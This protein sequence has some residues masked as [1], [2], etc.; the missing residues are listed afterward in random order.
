MMSF[1][2]SCTFSLRLIPFPRKP[3]KMEVFE[4]LVT[5]TYGYR[6]LGGVGETGNDLLCYGRDRLFHLHLTPTYHHFVSHRIAGE[7]R[8]ALSQK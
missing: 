6:Y 1:G 2:W 3:G 7:E 5:I 4:T 8:Q